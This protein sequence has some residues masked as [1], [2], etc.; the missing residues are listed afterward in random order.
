MSEVKHKK[1]TV[2]REFIKT[3][4]GRPRS[5]L[6]IGALN[7]PVFSKNVNVKYADRFSTADLAK[8]YPDKSGFVKVDYVLSETAFSEHIPEKFQCVVA[9]HVIEHIPDII[10]WL[11][12]LGNLVGIGGWAFLAI[13]DKRY[14]FDVIRPLT[15]LA[16]L[17][18]CA[19]R[20]LE[21]PSVGQ[22]F[23]HLYMNR[24]VTTEELWEGKPVDLS[25]PRIDLVKAVRTALKMSESYHSV[26]CH[27]FTSDS[28]AELMEQL[29]SANL[30]DWVLV[31]REEPRRGSNEFLVALK[32]VR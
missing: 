6:E 3:H 2:R 21:S 24:K 25:R 13:P 22:I 16:D 20:E 28:F 5:V 10:N 17:I 15:T 19:H 29:Y 26:H 1:V 30:A 12:Q 32:K 11:D 8:K 27:V 18:D 23:A 9:N 7:A 31:A 14:T 4:I